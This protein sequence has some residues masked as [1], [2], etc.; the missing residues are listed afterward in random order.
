MN[1]LFVADGQQ[2]KEFRRFVENT[3]AL[4]LRRVAVISLLK[5]VQALII[6]INHISTRKKFAPKY[7]VDFIICSF[8]PPHFCICII[9][10]NCEI[11]AFCYIKYSLL[12]LFVFCFRLS[13]YFHSLLFIAN[14]NP[15]QTM[16]KAEASALEPDL[17]TRK[18]KKY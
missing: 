13:Y 16:I 15:R 7:N 9:L 3:L 4:F 8:V 17:E 1:V 18:R 10:S 11:I 5:I 6:I 2:V 14:A 12:L